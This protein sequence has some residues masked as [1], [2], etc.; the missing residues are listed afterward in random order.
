MFDA[1]GRISEL[2]QARR[3][4]VYK[5]A[6][7][8][9]VPQSTIVTWYNK[10]RYPSIDK[11]E[12]ICNAFGITLSEFFSDADQLDNGKTD[13][14]L[15]DLNSKYLLLTDYQKEA[16]MKVIDAFIHE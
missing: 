5:L 2:R 16:L 8:A 15:A 11:L 7:L 14:E 9:D 10:N 12:S 6:K 13:A 3:L 4:S 1:L